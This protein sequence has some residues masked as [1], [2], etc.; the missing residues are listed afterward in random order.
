MS[1]GK[2]KPEAPTAHGVE[3]LIT[4]LRDEGVAEGRERAQ[5]VIAEAESRARWL[6]EQAQEEAD[7]LRENARQDAE[8]YRAS[9]EQA[10]SVAARDAILSLKSSLG[11]V[12]S[13][14]IERLVSDEMRSQ[15]LLRQLILT[16]AGRA[17]EHFDATERLEILLPREAFGLEE[18]RRKPSELAE[19]E[20]TVL[21]R[22]VMADSLRD[23]VTFA[24]ADD[25]RPGLRIRLV[26]RGITVDLTDLSVAALLQEH[27]Q[28]RFRALLE[29]IV[30]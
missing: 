29:G 10:L 25:D 26:D 20:L 24:A 22:S 11:Q 9:G 7:L 5:K 21:V 23:G 4:R 2:A 1:D 8:R 3:A 14:E 30:K 19:G 6:L 18:L 28:P 27:L 13:R 17:R 16:V 15:E 12:F